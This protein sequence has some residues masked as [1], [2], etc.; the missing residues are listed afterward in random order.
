MPQHREL[1]ERARQ[2]HHEEE[3]PSTEQ[4]HRGSIETHLIPF[5]GSRDLRMLTRDDMRAFIKNRFDE[6]RAEG[7]ITNALSVLRRVYSLHVES[8]LLERDPA[9][10]CGSW[11]RVSAGVTAARA[12]VR[13]MHGPTRK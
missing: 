12:C 10:R 4:T 1:P 2:E 3:T 11:R 7:A 5:F 8:G 9:A 13:W 6:G